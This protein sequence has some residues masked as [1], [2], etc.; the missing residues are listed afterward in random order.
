MNKKIFAS[1]SIRIHNRLEFNFN[2]ADK[3][4]LYINMKKYY[5]AIGE[6]VFDFLPLTFQIDTGEDDPIFLDFI[7]IFEI[8]K[9]KKMLNLWILKPGENCNRGNGI[10]VCNTLEQIKN[11]LK[12][13]PFP[14]TGEH[15]FI[16]QK[17]I[18][19]PFLINRRKFDI[20]LY[21]LVTSINGYIQAYYY[22]DGYIRT[23]CKEYNPKILDNKFIHLTNDAVQKK[24][25]DYGRY[26][27]ANKMSYI[28]FQRYL[29]SLRPKAYLNFFDDVIPQIKK[30][31]K[32]TIFAVH[33]KIDLRKRAY[34]FEIYG[35]DFLLDDHLKPWLIEV[36]T[37][38]CLELS[39]GIL[40]DIIPTMLENAFRI[41]VDPLFPHPNG[42]KGY[43]NY[44]YENNL[45]NKFELIFHE[46]YD[47][48]KL[49]E[50]LEQRRTLQDFLS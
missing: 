29:D 18:E 2:L 22:K 13:N 14:K 42:R 35:Y 39:P 48:P 31:T 11:E 40:A 23:S 36:N 19:K 34:G 5:Q 33:K 47:S 38:P 50:Q 37:N 20:R 12:N 24:S 44:F 10:C 3:K 43:S 15:T 28:E 41:A 16:I 1:A 7:R 17:Y 9:T 25:E 46:I 4:F 30:I 26:E 45:E 6:N 8:C 49:F 27:F 32:D 21:C